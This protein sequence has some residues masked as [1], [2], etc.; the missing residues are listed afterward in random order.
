M[1]DNDAP[2][3]L[4]VTRLIWRRWEGTRP[5]GIDRICEAWLDNYA[6]QSQ[7]VIIHKYGQA[8]LGSQTSQALFRLLREPV[9]QA[10][11]TIS[12]RAG[13]A[14]LALRRGI[15]MLGR[16]PGRGRVWLNPGH[17]GLDSPRIAKWVR[18]KHIRPVYLVHDLIPLTHPQYCRDGEDLRH[19]R[20]MRT[21]LDTAAAVVANSSDTLG[22]LQA[23]ARQE[24][25]AL[26]PSAI[27]WPGT[28]EFEKINPATDAEPSFVV[29]GTIEGRKNHKL[30]LAVWRNF[31]QIA[32]DT[33]PKLLIVGR[34]GWQAQ[35]VFD[36]LDGQD[37]NGKVIELGPLDDRSLAP[38]LANARALLFPSFAEGYG[39]PLIEALALGIPVI[40]NDLPVFRE[41]GQGVPD[42]LS[43]TD[44]A[45]WSEAILDFAATDSP[46]RAAQ[47]AK[48]R[49]FYKPEWQDHF[50][51]I[52]KL[53]SG[54]DC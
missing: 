12:F 43:S 4:D 51:A 13:L 19:K 22:L 36:T 14:A 26:A 48:L 53:L 50:E 20:R 45:A 18:D 29:L 34:R 46:R 9:R 24:G 37:F 11:D 5:T 41:I 30:L 3:L 54:L 27:A 6:S 44:V 10:G 28:P 21:V 15:D 38:V 8:I 2:L 31:L 7:A 33:A 35:D 42:F 17:T 16:L 52:D 32:P 40:A 23:F 1:R 25:K 49:H 47:M 39:M